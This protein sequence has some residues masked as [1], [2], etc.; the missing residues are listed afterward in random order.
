MLLSD[1]ALLPSRLRLAGAASG[2]RCDLGSSKPSVR[3]YMRP[4]RL[5]VASEAP[6]KASRGGA[7][8]R[9]YVTLGRWR[10]ASPAALDKTGSIGQM[11]EILRQVCTHLLAAFGRCSMA[12][13]EALCSHQSAAQLHPRCLRPGHLGSASARPCCGVGGRPS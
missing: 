5:E 12:K 10:N 3:H 8:S 9:R 13:L 7:E 4:S 11:L 1:G 6:Q 2:R